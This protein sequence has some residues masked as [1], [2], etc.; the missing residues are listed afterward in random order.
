ML[1]SNKYLQ[2]AE[3][4]AVFEQEFPDFSKRTGLKGPAWQ[5]KPYLG[6]FGTRNCPYCG[7]AA[8]YHSVDTFPDLLLMTVDHID[9]PR[10]TYV[11]TC[12]EECAAVLKQNFHEPRLGPSIKIRKY[13]LGNFIR[14]QW[15]HS[16][17]PLWS[18]SRMKLQRRYIFALNLHKR[19]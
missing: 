12:C 13:W 6:Y 3:L 7:E 10:K 14:K 8:S 1:R 2:E 17:A 19:G 16:R 9:A 5:Y 18:T 11:V 4:Q 15:H